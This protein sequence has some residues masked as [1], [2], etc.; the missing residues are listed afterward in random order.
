MT[1]RTPVIAAIGL[2]IYIWYRS[3]VPNNDVLG[4]TFVSQV[5]F[6]TLET[7]E[8]SPEAVEVIAESFI[9]TP[10]VSPT[11]SP[12]A[13]LAIKETPKPTPTSKP[14]PDFTSEQIYGFTEKYGIL[15]AV[16]PNVL[17]HVALCE[18]GFNPRAKNFIYSGL[19]QYDSNT[20]RKYRGEIGQD[21]DP[22]LRYHAEEAVETTAFALSHG[23][24]R[25]WPNCYPK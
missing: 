21:P 4:E 9:A 22:D 7:A 18:S 12:T 2:S 3:S 16:D 10:S 19:F 13:T 17:R 11:A 8:S 14:Q 20:W 5:Q 23:A 6:D 25:L 24:S 1:W 15:Y